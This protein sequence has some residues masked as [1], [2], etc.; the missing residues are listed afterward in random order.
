MKTLQILGTLA[1]WLQ[2]YI[3]IRTY[4]KNLKHMIQTLSWMHHSF[5]IIHCKGIQ[6]QQNTVTGQFKST[7]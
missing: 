2:I 1:V 4:D 6:F 3:A 7:N 5:Q